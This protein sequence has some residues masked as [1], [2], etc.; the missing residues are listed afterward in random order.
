MAKIKCVNCSSKPGKRKCLINNG[1][2]ICPVCCATIRDDKCMECGYYQESAEFAARKQEKES[3][4]TPASYFGSPAMQKSIMEASMDL[5]NT[6]ASVG[7]EYDKDPDKF[8]ADSFEFFNTDEF[9]EFSFTDEE[10]DQIM[11]EYGE[12]KD[13]E[14]W[15]HTEEGTMYYSSAVSLIMNDKRFREFSKQLMN[16]F[17]KYYRK[18]DFKNAWL[19]LS[20]TNRIMESDYVI[21]FTILMFFRG[22]SRWKLGRDMT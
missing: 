1:E 16:I 7:G 3:S 20:T 22:I 12:P 4:S 17:L 15:F 8:I 19:I 2:L 13:E 10:I 6:H 21:P 11:K 5:M 18:Q 14:G 9:S